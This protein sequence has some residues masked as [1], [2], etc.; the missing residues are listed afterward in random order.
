MG[1][2]IIIA[3]IIVICFIG[4]KGA[5]KRVQ[6]GCCGAGGNT[7]KKVKAEDEDLSHYNYT[8]LAQVNGMT[9]SNCK[10]AVENEF[11]SH[12]CMAEANVNK[13]NVRIH[14]KEPMEPS[15]IRQMIW[16]SGYEPGT[17][18]QKV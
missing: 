18:E 16:H 8:Y 12:G 10:R 17:V 9:C 7:V 6:H 14:S 1:N 4:V 5:V 15:V 13:K 2:A 11:I 3:V